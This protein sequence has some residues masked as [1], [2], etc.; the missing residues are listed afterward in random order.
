LTAKN[1]DLLV[2]SAPLHDIGKVGI[3]DTILLKPDKLDEAEWEIMKMHTLLGF[4]AIEQAERDTEKPVEFFT[5][6]KIIARHHHEKFR[7]S[8]WPGGRR[9]SDCRTPNGVGRCF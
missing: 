6:A 7:L 1:I 9:H 2:K 5:F 3:P 4:D 8:R